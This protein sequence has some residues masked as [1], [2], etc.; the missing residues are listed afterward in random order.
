LAAVEHPTKIY[1]GCIDHGYARCVGRIVGQI[2]IAAAIDNGAGI[3]GDTLT[4]TEAADE[5]AATAARP[6]GSYVRPSG[7]TT[8]AQRASVQGLP[9]VE[10]GAVTPVQVADHIYPLVREWYETGGINEEFMRSLEAVQP[11][12]PAC[13]ASQGG[14]L[15]W[16]SRSMKELFGFG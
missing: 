6:P 13:S 5:V 4:A 1:R 2:A 12:C 9:C 16:W 11:Q 10:C 3:L 8:A 15:S 14:Q 7:A